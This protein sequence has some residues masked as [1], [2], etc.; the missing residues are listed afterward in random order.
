[1]VEE[2]TELAIGVASMVVGAIGMLA[3]VEIPVSPAMTISQLVSQFGGLGLAVWL[4]I[5]HTMITIPSMQKSHAEERR[6]LFASFQK[7]LDE[8]RKDYAAEI[9]RQREEFAVMLSRF[10]CKVENKDK[11]L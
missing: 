4:V 10:Q 2:K 3:Q 7:T 11:N 5:H 1:M 9:D 6:E 8:K